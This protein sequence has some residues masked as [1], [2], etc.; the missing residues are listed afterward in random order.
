[1]RRLIRILQT[2]PAPGKGFENP[3]SVGASLSLLVAAGILVQF[4][5]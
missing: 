1:M 4:V 2:P 5:H 3:Y